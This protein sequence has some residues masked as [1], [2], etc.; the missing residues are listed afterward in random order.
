ME[1]L[2]VTKNEI[3]KKELKEY[4]DFLSENQHTMQNYNYIERVIELVEE[5]Q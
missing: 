5:I 1:T 2:Q 3:I 4:L